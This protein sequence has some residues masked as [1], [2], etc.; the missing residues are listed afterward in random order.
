MATGARSVWA[1]DIGSCSLKALRL[2]STGDRIEVTGL[3][4]IEHP[5]ILSVEG[6]S[7]EEKNQI[8]R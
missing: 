5:K 8:I 1:I 6:I 3:D 7:E 2:Q 4:Y